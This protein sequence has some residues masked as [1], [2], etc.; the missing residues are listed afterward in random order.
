MKQDHLLHLHLLHFLIV[1]PELLLSLSVLQVFFSFFISFNPSALSLYFSW[2]FTRA[3][4]KI[5]SFSS[6]SLL[7]SHSEV[8]LRAHIDKQKRVCILAFGLFLT[9]D[10]R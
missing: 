7:F 6:A 8:C 9:E 1:F 5:L 10:L 2:F 3:R 4:F